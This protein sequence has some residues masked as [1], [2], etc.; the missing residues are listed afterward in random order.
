MEETIDLRELVA[1]LAKGKWL[2]AAVTAVAVIAAALVSY[3]VMKPV[4]STSATVSVDNGLVEEKEL[5]DT[6]RYLKEVITPAI[7][8]ERIKNVEVIEAAIKEKWCK[9]L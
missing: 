4:Y 1:I 2:I 9:K 8:T 7:Y 3:L 5:S 6:D